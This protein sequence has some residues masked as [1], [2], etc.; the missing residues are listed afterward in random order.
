MSQS[1][2]GRAAAPKHLFFERGS[3]VKVD[4]AFLVVVRLSVKT[5]RDYQPAI[6][7][8]TNLIGIEICVCISVRHQ[9]TSGVHGVV[10]GVAETRGIE[11]A[12]SR[13]VSNLQC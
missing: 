5:G 13:F 2:T 3:T 8:L 1:I 4:S 10:W 9:R 11:G 6:R 12:N 7:T